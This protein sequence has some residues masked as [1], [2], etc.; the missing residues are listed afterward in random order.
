MKEM[1]IIL[2]LIFV[3]RIVKKPDIKVLVLQFS[4]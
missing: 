1:K 3:T 2:G 4:L